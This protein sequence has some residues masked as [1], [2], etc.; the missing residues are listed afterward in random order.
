MLPVGPSWEEAQRLLAT[1]EGD[2]PKNIRD[3]AI[4]ML[5]LIYGLRSGEV[6]ALRLEDL[7]WER[8][9]INVPRGKQ[10]STQCYP[11]TST[12]G[13]AIL[14]YLKEARPRSTHREIFLSMRAPIHPLVP[15]S[16]Y[17]VVRNRL[18]PLDDSLRPG[19]QRRHQQRHRHRGAQ[20][21][22]ATSDHRR[23]ARF[24]VHRHGEAADRV[25]A[26]RSCA[27]ARSRARHG[28]LGG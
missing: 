25:G 8:E 10:R 23:P 6:C 9:L 4:L 19:G 16:L 15:E 17:R 13:E 12:V 2:Q 26:Y 3:R 28:P 18:R 11:L 14:R 1:T 5:L 22:G 21:K 7:D 24:C 27:R 20:R